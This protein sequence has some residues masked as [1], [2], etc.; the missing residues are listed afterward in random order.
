ML[1]AAS[2]RDRR[3]YMNKLAEREKKMIIEDR[4]GSSRRSASCSTRHKGPQYQDAD[5]DRSDCNGQSF[6]AG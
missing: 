6:V 5:I 3:G 2:D 1:V 4:S